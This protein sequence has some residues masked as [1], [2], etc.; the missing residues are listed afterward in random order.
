M[1]LARGQPAAVKGIP[2]T[3]ASG[4]IS[5]LA[6][7][8]RGEEILRCEKGVRVPWDCFVVPPP[9]AGDSSQR[10]EVGDGVL[11]ETRHWRASEEIK[12]TPVRKRGSFVSTTA[13]RPEGIM[14]HSNAVRRFR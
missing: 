5:N 9:T 3:P 10:R 14:D 7:S 2:L 1:S 11:P 8:P 4:R 6:L 13:Y 12:K